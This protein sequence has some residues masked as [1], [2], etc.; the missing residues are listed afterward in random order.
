[1]QSIKCSLSQLAESLK[2][3]FLNNL[4]ILIVGSPGI[5]K[6]DTVDQICKEL[7]YDLIISHPVVSDPTDY[8]GFP[9]VIDNKADFIPFGDLRQLIEAKKETV[10]FLDDL[11][12]SPASVQAACMQLLLSRQINGHKISEKIRF[13]AATNRREDKAGVRSEEHTSELQSPFLI[14]YAVSL[15]RKSVV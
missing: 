13:V 7:N 14:S 10:Y 6:T 15:D 8:K 12:Q 3:A 4:N 5:G 11:G 1:M 9:F 2:F